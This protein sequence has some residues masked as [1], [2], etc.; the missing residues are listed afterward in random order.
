MRGGAFQCLSGRN[1][2]GGRLARCHRA[3]CQRYQSICSPSTGFFKPLHW[4]RQ[5]ATENAHATFG[6]R[7]STSS[8]RTSGANQSLTSGAVGTVLGRNGCRH[9]WCQQCPPFPASFPPWR[10]VSGLH[11]KRLWMPA[12]SNRWR[13]FLRMRMCWR[14]AGGRLA[15]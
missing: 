6:E 11:R 12:K 2:D 7:K 3:R 14:A 13:R 4:D 1:K 8:G 15:H 9:D 5:A 10:F